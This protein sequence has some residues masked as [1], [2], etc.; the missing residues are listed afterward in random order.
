MLLACLWL[1]VLLSP[2]APGQ[3]P[4]PPGQ[5]GAFTVPGFAP[6]SVLWVPGD[7]LPG[8]HP[9]LVLFMHGAGASPTTWPWRGALEGKGCLILGLSYAPLDGAGGQ[10]IAADRKN[11]LAMVD[12][13]A[14]AIAAVV[15]R[16]GAD[17]RRV[18][19]TGLS[20]GGWGVNFYGLCQ[21]AKDLFLAYGILAAGPNR[22]GQLVDFAVARDRAVLLLNG[23]R[24]PNLAAANQGRP[25]L[26]QA[27]ARVTQVVLP[28][29]G[30]VP[31]LDSMKPHLA[32]WL[33]GVLER[34][35]GG[36]GAVAWEALTLPAPPPGARD[37]G[38]W[39]LGIEELRKEGRP[40]LLFFCSD[41][42]GPKGL[43]PACRASRAAE[44]A[45]F[46]HPGACGV[47]A[48]ARHFRCIRI[49][50]AA[51][52]TAALL[53]EALAPVAVL[54]ARDGGSSVVLRKDRIKDAPLLAEMRKLLTVEELS[55]TDQR[56]ARTKPRLEVLRRLQGRI[57]KEAATL[58]RVAGK[59][60]AEPEKCRAR[61]EELRR[62]EAALLE[63]LNGE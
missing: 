39:L 44:E 17:P 11:S 29:E 35:A 56:I 8:S 27:G 1:Q 47:P 55:A 51:A 26:E 53:Q 45:A 20:M 6:P 30:H 36:R 58:A 52:P 9:P 38:A 12:Y 40:V 16:Y 15:E 61:L 42:E 24:D 32:A 2:A 7:F 49:E 50:L 34:K 23:E 14:K 25:A 59:A 13:L 10:G 19:L 43:A 33:L 54:L 57:A 46:R 37:L 28:G 3:T 5:E 21:E 18:I 63:E 4:I 41:A 62:E 48:A 60:G 22:Q 31:S